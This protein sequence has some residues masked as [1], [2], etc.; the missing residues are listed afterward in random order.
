MRISNIEDVRFRK[1]WPVDRQTPLFEVLANED[2]LFDV[3]RTSTGFD[4]AF[5]SAASRYIW[6][7]ALLRKVIAEV[8]IRI[9]TA[10]REA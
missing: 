8:E 6:D 9:A 7:V 10:E 3:G 4:V 5:H 1:F 2:I